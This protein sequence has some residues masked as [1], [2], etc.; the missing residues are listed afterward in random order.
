MEK[1]L[2]KLQQDFPHLHFAPGELFS[3]SSRK[4]TVNYATTPP[5]AVHAVWSLL[6]EMGHALLDHASYQTDFELVKMEAA[7]WDKA[8]E[9]GKK[10][11]HLIDM[12]HIQDCLDTYR[13]WLYQRS[14]CP[15]CAVTS[16]QKDMHTYSC[17]NCNTEWRVSRSK[18]C[19]P[20]R[21][22]QKEAA[23]S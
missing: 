17:Y 12:D 23:A 18:L 11:R 9:L 21:L 22:L 2:T 20:Y 8:A 5:D 19:R 4:Q 3:W 7:A 10:Y 6:H 16:L 13:D 1:L 15:K 14:K